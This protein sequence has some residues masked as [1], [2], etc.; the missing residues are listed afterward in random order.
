QKIK[1]IIQTTKKNAQEKISNAQ[2][3]AQEMIE[4]WSKLP[5]LHSL[6]LNILPGSRQRHW[7]TW[8]A[9]QARR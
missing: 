3:I 9:C 2:T 1:R 5:V 6:G 7:V 4:K 8:A